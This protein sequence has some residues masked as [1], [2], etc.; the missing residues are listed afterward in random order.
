MV[1]NKKNIFT[2]VYVEAVKSKVKMLARAKLPLKFLEK[3]RVHVSFLASGVVSS[4]WR[5]LA[6]NASLQSLTVSFMWCSRCVSCGLDYELII[7]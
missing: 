6:L 7:L 3:N 5:S 1:E 4:P 2:K